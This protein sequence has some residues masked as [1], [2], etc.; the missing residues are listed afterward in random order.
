MKKIVTK[1]IESVIHIDDIKETDLIVVKNIKIDKIVGFI[2]TS[3]EENYSLQRSVTEKVCAN[4]VYNT[5]SLSYLIK[6]LQKD[7]MQ[8]YKI[9]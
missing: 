7:D 6:V 1:E 3:P 5:E 9:G 8:C 4:P 2:T